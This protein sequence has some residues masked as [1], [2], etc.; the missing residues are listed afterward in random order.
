MDQ[1]GRNTREGKERRKGEWTKDEGRRER[2]TKGG[3]ESGLKRKKDES[4]E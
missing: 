3:K 1:R 2:G 4:G